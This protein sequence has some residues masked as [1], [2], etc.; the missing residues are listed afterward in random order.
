MGIVNLMNNLPG[1]LVGSP[2]PDILNGDGLTCSAAQ[3]YV[4]SP[5]A[6]ITG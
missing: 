3:A 6:E 4:M 1:G 2:S 5:E